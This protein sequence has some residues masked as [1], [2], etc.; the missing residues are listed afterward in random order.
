MYLTEVGAD[1]DLNG[2]VAEFTREI[3]GIPFLT[4]LVSPATA[5]LLATWPLLGQLLQQ[6]YEKLKTN[7]VALPPLNHDVI[8][9]GQVLFANIAS[10]AHRLPILPTSITN[11]NVKSISKSSNDF[12]V[13][14]SQSGEYFYF[15]DSVLQIYLTTTTY[16]MVKYPV[17]GVFQGKSGVMWAKNGNSMIASAIPLALHAQCLC[18]LRPDFLRALYSRILLPVRTA[19]LISTYALES[20]TRAIREALTKTGLQLAQDVIKHEQESSVWF[21]SK[22]A[23]K[24]VKNVTES[25]GLKTLGGSADSS[26]TKTTTK[27]SGNESGYAVLNTEA[28]DD[29]TV[30]LPEY[31]EFDVNPA[32]VACLNSQW[33]LLL[34]QAASAPVHSSPWKALSTL[35]Y[36]TNSLDHI[37]IALL[38]L[39]LLKNLLSDAK[40]SLFSQ[41]S[42]TRNLGKPIDCTTSKPTSAMSSS[43]SSSSSSSTLSFLSMFTTPWGSTKPSTSASSAME[44]ATKNSFTVSSHDGTMKSSSAVFE[45]KSKIS[46]SAAIIDNQKQ[47]ENL[48]SNMDDLDTKLV[49]EGPL[50][51]VIVVACLLRVHLIALD[52][53][54]LYT[55]EVTN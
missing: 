12:E 4:C 47:L 42:S 39:P 25:I 17:P 5:F 51:A 3:L 15:N 28:E 26:N 53:S 46:A 20:D 52:D 55:Q 18:L 50:A 23:S 34:T 37:W 30:T 45:N 38:S 35:A 48:A 33:S 21:T 32:L 7:S 11:T 13:V 40:D 41:S 49:P 44:V 24:L 19:D 43:S 2:R 9:S 14:N 8:Q 6:L 10:L 36:S 54:E 16:L 1:I 27:G 31:S 22:W 29:N